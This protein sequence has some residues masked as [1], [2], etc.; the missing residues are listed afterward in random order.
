MNHRRRGEELKSGI[1][2]FVADYVIANRMTPSV[3]EI[4]EYFRTSKSTIHDYLLELDAEGV[5]PYKRKIGIPRNMVLRH[6]RSKM[7]QK[8]ET[9][10]FH[11]SPE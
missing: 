8:T 5:I 6:S 9:G 3:G 1:P 10:T 11:S 2:E 4:A 7:K